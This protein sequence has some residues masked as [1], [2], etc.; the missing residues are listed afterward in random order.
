MLLSIIIPIYKVEKYIRGTLES[1][2]CQDFDEHKF[3]VICVN[4]GTPDNSMLIV[5]EF[6]A[7]YDNL[8]IVN[9]EN[10]GLSCARNAGLRIAKGDYIWFV[11]S[12]DRIVEGSIIQLEK[13]ISKEIDVDFFGFNIYKVQENSNIESIEQ[14]VLNK[15]NKCL[16]GHCVNV[17]QLIHKVHIAPVQRFVFKKSFF[18]KHHLEFY[19]KILHEDKELMVKA[20]FLAKKIMLVNYSP[21]YY[22]LRNS[23]SIMSSIDMK[24]VYS[25][26]TIIDSFQ[27]FKCNHAEGMQSKIYFNDNVYLQTL[28]ILGMQMES[29]EYKAVIKNNSLLFRKIAFNGLL[30]NIYY[31]DMRKVI[32]AIIVLISPSLYA[33]LK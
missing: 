21:Y 29:V 23:G 11:D 6:V 8:Y 18:H 33:N 5:D 27:N 15:K 28:D 4:D 17:H 3:E 7:R 26:M 14:I 9:Q 24:S 13:I 19:P 16:Y 31:G 25:K 10:Q 30:T 2:Y 1:I 22:L 12:D 20:F 32:K